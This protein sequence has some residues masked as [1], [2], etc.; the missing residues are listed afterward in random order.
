MKDNHDKKSGKE[1]ESSSLKKAE[2][3]SLLGD[4]F[5]GTAS[6]LVALPS[7]IAFGLIIYAP[8]GSEFSGQAALGGIIGTIML[9]LVAPLVGGTK[10]LV[11]APCAPAA[12]VLSVFVAE[13]VSA[14]SV[15]QSLI[16]IYITLVA[17]LSGTFQ[18]LAGFIGGGRFIKYIP[19]P[20]VA[21]YLSGVGVLIFIGQLPKFLGITEKINF[22]NALGSFELWNLESIII[23]SVTIIVMLFA[24][25]VTKTIPAAILS[26]IFGIA[27]Y[28]VLAIYNSQLLILENN[29]MIIGA[30]SAS[31]GDVTNYIGSHLSLIAQIDLSLISHVIVPV[32]TLGVLLSID[33]L[34]TCVVLDALTF[35]RHN[36]NRELIGQ[37][38]GNIASA[39]ACGIPGAGTMGATLVN[40]NSGG[41]TK[42]SGMFV[43]ITA[44]FVLLLLGKYVA[45]IPISALAGILMVVGIRM[46]D[47][48]S[49]E[50]L[51]SK[52]TMLDFFVTL[53]VI[54]SAI[55]YSLI[56]AAGV[57]IALA[58]LLFLREQIRTSVIRR[59]MKV[60]QIFSKKVRLENEVDI[61]NSKSDLTLVLELQGQLFFGTTDQLLT[62]L[63]PFLKKCK[64]IILD[65][66]RVASVD[67]TAGNLLRQI[68]ARI[69]TQKGILIFSSVP[70]SLPT[71]Q[72]VRKYLEDLGM[73]EK[74]RLKFFDTLDQAVEWV[75]DQI[76]SEE[77]IAVK[78]ESEPLNVE[79]LELF[80][81]LSH[82]LLS[83]MIKAM[84]IKDYKPAETIF[85]IGEES[86][87]IYFIRKGN[88]KIVLPLAG[89]MIHHLATFSRGNF[90]G[91]MAFLDKGKRSANAVA[92]D[93]VSLY[94]LKRSKFD[95]IAIEH[96]KIAGLFFERFAYTISSRLR[97]N[98]TEL[99][100]LQEI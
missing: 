10:K 97:Q 63:E 19:Y 60:G 6:M 33:T 50:L 57:G 17:F 34:K 94:V 38:A 7:A 11:T 49:F 62:E 90:F 75:E 26:L 43:G 1:N 41:Q 88:V 56:T 25:K 87:E 53:A 37:G 46:I 85:S 99:K 51:K 14:G 65:L 22:W 61:L 40:L 8:L 4:I 70:M 64:Y 32:F 100:A 79:E 93:D 74:K 89:G 9:G 15:E 52:T 3:S 83:T 36:S 5:G 44:L 2:R 66:R 86:E 92:A 16:P 35:S 76:L 47:K 78:D 80:E 69:K 21:G 96:P 68:K 98:N 71:G 54:L 39:I 58:I 12:A 42:Y 48:K 81:D 13:M 91:D 20:V 31:A 45:W 29:K 30:I 82:D 24:S 59:K 72:N 23:G 55:S 73:A 67:Y 95:E 27:C 28:F 18:M 84:E 77:K